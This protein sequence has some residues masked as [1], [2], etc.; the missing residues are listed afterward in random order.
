MADAEARRAAIKKAS[1]QVR[2]GGVFRRAAT[3][4]KV[5]PATNKTSASNKTSAAPRPAPPKG[6]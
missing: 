4:S 5:S 2:A 1:Q 3:S 6:H